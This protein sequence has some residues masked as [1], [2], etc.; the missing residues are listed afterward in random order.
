[1]L[2]SFK[3]CPVWVKDTNMAGNDGERFMAAENEAECKEACIANPDCVAFDLNRV[4]NPMQ[5][6]L[7]TNPENIQG[8]NRRVEDG[9]DMYINLFWPT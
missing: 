7:H 6:W 3:A 8:G 4:E 2:W 1:M 9:V 5:C